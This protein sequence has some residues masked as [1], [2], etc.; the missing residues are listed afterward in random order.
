MTH[1]PCRGHRL[2]AQHFAAFELIAT[3]NPL[4]NVSRYVIQKLESLGLI[5]QGTPKKHKDVLGEFEI[6]QY[7]VPI[8]HHA[9]WCQWCSEQQ[10]NHDK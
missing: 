7:E 6:P 2:N 4:P 3:G 10:N 5:G 9:Q 1:H 8:H